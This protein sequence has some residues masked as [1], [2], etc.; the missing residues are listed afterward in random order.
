MLP[1][2]DRCFDAIAAHDLIPFAALANPLNAVMPAHIIFSQVDDKP[3][4]FS[5]YWLQTVLRQQLGFSGVIFS[6]DIS[7]EGATFA[8]DYGQRAEAA[9]TAGCDM[10]LVCNNREGVGQVLAHL[11]S[12]ADHPSI[13][14]ARLSSMR[15]L[16]SWDRPSLCKDAR[17]LKTRALLGAI[18]G[19]VM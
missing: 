4:G 3:V 12:L 2:D 16:R 5:P 11:S 10:V 14:P 15:A 6:D 13:T 19:Q 1:V 8:G 17:Y 7:M 18:T 9:L